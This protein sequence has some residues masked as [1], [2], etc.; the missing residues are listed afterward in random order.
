MGNKFSTHYSCCSRKIRAEHVYIA[1]SHVSL[2]MHVIVL[3]AHVHVQFRYICYT[4]PKAYA[5]IDAKRKLSYFSDAKFNCKQHN[6]AFRSL[7]SNVCIRLCCAVHCV[8]HSTRH[9]IN[10]M[11]LHS[12]SSRILR[13]RIC[14]YSKYLKC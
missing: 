4:A 9:H 2:L 6:I 11:T 3:Y 1:Y 14:I 13:R 7:H 12:K 5:R 8:L 10:L